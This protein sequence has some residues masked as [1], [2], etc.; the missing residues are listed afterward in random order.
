M[1][2]SFLNQMQNPEVQNFMT[3]PQVSQSVEAAGL[4]HHLL[5]SFYAVCVFQVTQAKFIPSF[6]SLSTLSFTNM[7]V[8]F[9]YSICLCVICLI[10]YVSLELPPKCVHLVCESDYWA[11]RPVCLNA[12]WIIS[13]HSFTLFAHLL[14][15]WH[16]TFLQLSS[17]HI[18][19]WCKLLFIHCIALIVSLPS[20]DLD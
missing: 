14:S 10:L 12:R 13:Y 7:K 2:P 8:P 19:S 18:Q 16:I 3:N 17:K 6:V 9:L 4:A 20:Y 5:S 1:L 11:E 15:C